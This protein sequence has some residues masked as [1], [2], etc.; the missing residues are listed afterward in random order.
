[1]KVKFYAPS[2]RR[3][4]KS[5][6]QKI[7]PFVT[8]VVA[9]EEADDYRENGNVIQVV[10]NSAQGN[11]C[12]IRNYILD[13][14]F[15]DAD[16]L[17]L[18]DDDCKAITYWEDQV[19]YEMTADQ[20]DEFAE[21]GA[22]LCQEYGFHFWGVNCLTDKGAYREH[23]PLSTVSYIGGPFQAHLKSSRIRYDENLPLKEDYDMT[24]QHCH[25]NGGAL[26]FNFASYKVKQAE[27]AGG[28]AMYRNTK[29]EEEQFKALQR[30]WGSEVVKA[31]N[32]SRKKFDFNP[33]IKIPI[34]GV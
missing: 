30:K 33:I 14:L 2:Y 10:P 1:M 9:E 15:G 26:R 13:N 22:I 11:L 29:R 32:S 7:Y 5:I 23:T 3:P 28:C 34:R 8:L 18:L 16:C 24:L 17:V 20:L 19:L 4:E 31:D 12:R 6:T 27:Q 25:Q 21:M